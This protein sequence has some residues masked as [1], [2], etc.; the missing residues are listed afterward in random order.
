VPAHG[1]HGGTVG[2]AGQEAEH[3]AQDFRQNERPRHHRHS[4]RNAC[5]RPLPL[6]VERFA[7]EKSERAAGMT[8][9][10]NNRTVEYR[11]GELDSPAVSATGSISVREMR[12]RVSESDEAISLY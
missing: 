2:E 11:R 3:D 8:L 10:R 4:R 1:P 5:R 7:C 6:F 9:P 12:P